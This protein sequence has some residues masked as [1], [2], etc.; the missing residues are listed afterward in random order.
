MESTKRVWLEFSILIWLLLNLIDLQLTYLALERGLS[1]ANL[2][3]SWVGLSFFQFA[4]VKTL[5]VFAIV[6]WVRSRQFI[7]YLNVGMVV[8]IVWNLIVIGEG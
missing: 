3:M 4:A 1:E 2:L 8:V 7:G 5:G 6:L